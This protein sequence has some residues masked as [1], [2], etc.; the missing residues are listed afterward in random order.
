MLLDSYLKQLRLPGFLN[1]WRSFAVDAA[2]SNLSYDRFLLALAEQEVTRRE[3]NGREQRIKSAHFPMIK[4]LADFDFTAIPR[5]NRS[6]V[7]QLAESGYIPKAES[8]IMVGVPGVGKTHVAIS[9]GIQACRQGYRVRFYN[10]AALVNELIQAQDDHRLSKFLASVSKQ[11][12]II[13]DELGFIPFS[14][15][16]SHL[17]FQF[18]S[19]L[20]ERVSM[21]VTS[22]LSFADWTQVF[23]DERLT[24]ALLDRLT[25]RAH[26]LEF[27]GDSYRFRQRMRR[28][29]QGTP[30][31]A[32][33]D[34]HN[35]DE[36]VREEGGNATDP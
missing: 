31:D 7:L 5:L 2:N 33:S 30:N 17:M 10:A 14:S 26:I 6:K 35:D 24:A 20:Y 9:L 22:N 15:A 8:V 25:H 4:E 12:L 11:Q 36:E 27:I 28:Q 23:G 34:T 13:I 32:H 21:M 3:Q 18:F 19:N 16:G 1:H 29:K